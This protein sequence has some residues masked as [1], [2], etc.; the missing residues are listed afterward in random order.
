MRPRALWPL[1][2][3]LLLAAVAEVTPTDQQSALFVTREVQHASTP[4]TTVRL[5]SDLQCSLLC[6]WTPDCLKWI[7]DP[8]T[9]SCRLLPLH[10]A[11]NPLTSDPATVHQP[12]HPAG[13]IPMPGGG[14][15]TYRPHSRRTPG[16][17]VLIELCREDDPQAVPAFITTDDQF[18]FLMT[19]PFPYE[20]QWISNNDY[21]EEGVYKDLFNTT[22]VDISQNWISSFRHYFNHPGYGGI[23]FAEADGLK[24]RFSNTSY[25]Y[26]C[27]YWM[28]LN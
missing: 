21:E 14:G 27:E 23:V 5:S 18:N 24:N 17:P 20:Y 2:V 19:L 6:L 9:A 25:S 12:P 16:G 10:S 8:D 26:L 22:V 1:L 13:Y 4:L 28:E 11:D 7:R 15:V 3:P